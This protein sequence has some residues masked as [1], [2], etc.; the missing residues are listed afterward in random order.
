[1]ANAGLGPNRG[2]QKENMKSQT[3]HKPDGQNETLKREGQRLVQKRAY[4]L[5]LKRGQ[6]PG[7]ELEDWL[8][9][10]REIGTLRERQKAA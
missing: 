3:T 5:Y 9:A 2:N 8:Q 4:E 7:H 10:E 6:E 1:M